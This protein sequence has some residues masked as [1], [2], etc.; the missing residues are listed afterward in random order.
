MKLA[1]K[2]KVLRDLEGRCRGRERG[3]SKAETAKLI[4][5]ETGERIS[6]PY[7]SQLEGGT[8]GHMTNKTRLLL[9]GFFRVHPGFLVDDPDDFRH[10]LAT[11]VGDR[12]QSLGAWLRLGA[13]RFRNDR[14]VA[15]TLERL[16]THPERRRALDLLRRVLA[17]PG[18][19]DS[20][21]HT[22]DAK[23]AP[24]TKRG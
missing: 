7:L 6:L 5:Q 16:A 13:E 23:R 2:L 21:L 1:E 12:S 9:A 17:V 24:T 3:L 4:H 18:L 19:M 15:E 11:P 14:L 10:E 20:L 22:L 8:R